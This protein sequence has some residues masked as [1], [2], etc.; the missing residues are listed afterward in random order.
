MRKRKKT[1]IT[2]IRKEREDIT[3]NLTEREKITREHCEQLYV[4]KL[5]NLDEMEKFLAK[6]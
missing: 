3:T 5:D 1:Q 4:I 6:H 2:K